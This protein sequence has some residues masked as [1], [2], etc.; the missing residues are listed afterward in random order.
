MDDASRAVN[1]DAEGIWL[2]RR[3]HLK[4]TM[5]PNERFN[6]LLP[7]LTN[8][9]ET[10]MM[11]PKQGGLKRSSKP[12]QSHTVSCRQQDMSQR[13]GRHLSARSK[14]LWDTKSQ[15]YGALEVF[16]RCDAVPDPNPKQ[17]SETHLKSP[18]PPKGKMPSTD[19][20][21]TFLSY[22]P[23]DCQRHQTQKIQTKLI[24]I[25]LNPTHVE[26]KRMDTPEID[27]TC[28]ISTIWVDIEV[29]S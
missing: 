11:W 13:H 9:S 8:W 21:D 20:T 26:S 10:G 24:Y 23:F 12:I 15:P 19:L 4:L 3:H 18:A 5:N 7:S 17:A 28:D 22:L 27:A 14:Q 16:S 2:N 1:G 25:V 29:Q 6:Q